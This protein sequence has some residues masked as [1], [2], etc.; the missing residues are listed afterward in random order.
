MVT[1]TFACYL[2]SLITG[3]TAKTEKYEAQGLYEGPRDLYFSYRQNILGTISENFQKILAA[4]GKTLLKCY[5]LSLSFF[6]NSF[7]KFTENF[8]NKTYFSR[9][10]TDNL[11][12]SFPKNLGFNC[13]Q[14]LCKQ[15]GRFI[16]I[17]IDGPCSIIQSFRLQHF[18]YKHAVRE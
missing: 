4:E 11:F 1:I 2:I 16:R 5:N 6:P 12:S 17:C 3:W 7:R 14:V 10:L 18:E 15:S 9:S 8:W 13:D